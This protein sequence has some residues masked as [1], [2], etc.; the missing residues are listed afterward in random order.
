MGIK[1]FYKP[2]NFVPVFSETFMLKVMLA[3]IF[4]GFAA[5]ILIDLIKYF[6]KRAH[7]INIWEPAKGL[8][9]GVA[10]V[11]M[12]LLASKR[13]L[14]LGLNVIEDSLR[15]APAHW[16]DFVMKS[17]FTAITLSFGGSGGIITPIF[18]SGRLRAVSTLGRQ[19]GFNESGAR[20]C[21]A[22][23]REHFGKTD[24]YCKIS[25]IADVAQR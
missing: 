25:I 12:T 18:L 6:K 5:L 17:V 7:R 14:G 13:Y 19:V 16:Y 15:G 9:G 1:Y 24:Y 8:I 4:C 3:G 21:P 11:I 23:R 22:S 2:L 10:L 20:H